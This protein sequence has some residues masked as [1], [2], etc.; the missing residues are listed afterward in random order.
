MPNTK[1]LLSG[2]LTP[3][4]DALN[5]YQIRVGVSTLSVQKGQYQMKKLL[6]VTIL[7]ALAALAQVTTGRIEGTVA[8]QQGASVVGAN[9]K[10]V[11]ASTGQT[12]ESTS[13]EKGIWVF[14]S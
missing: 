2:K 5:M 13:D 4:P 6:F 9:I 12:L 3:T 1:I 14:P 11:N 8:D 7:S 10:V